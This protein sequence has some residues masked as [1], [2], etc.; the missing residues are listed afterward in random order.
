MIKKTGQ[1]GYKISRSGSG[2]LL[3]ISVTGGYVKISTSDI[4]KSISYLAITY[5][6]SEGTV[7]Y[8]KDGILYGNSRVKD[9]KSNN[10]IYIAYCQGSCRAKDFIG[11]VF[12]VKWSNYFKSQEYFQ[13]NWER[14]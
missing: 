8:Y 4:K 1:T 14:S 7:Y 10:P 2:L 5:K 9:K 6:H 3:I 11:N 13:Q 12:A